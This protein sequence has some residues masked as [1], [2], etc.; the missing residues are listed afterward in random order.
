MCSWCPGC[1]AG[2]SLVRG[3][4]CQGLLGLVFTSLGEHLYS[5]SILIFGEQ[6]WE[7]NIARIVN[8]V[9]LNLYF[10]WLQN[11]RSLLYCKFL[12]NKSWFQNILFLLGGFSFTTFTFAV[13][14]LGWMWFGLT[15]NLPSLQ[16][17]ISGIPFNLKDC[18]RLYSC[19][20]GMWW[21]C[22]G[23]KSQNLR[24]LNP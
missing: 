16:C 4:T 21:W 14:C 18:L 9:P 22:W 2:G 8:A 7:W 12:S 3:P 15:K 10:F 13:S 5:N 23:N 11:D 20:Y 17:K 24:I 6:V 1:P 19:D